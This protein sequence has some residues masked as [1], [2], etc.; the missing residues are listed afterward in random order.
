LLCT[1]IA[2]SAAGVQQ[3]LDPQLQLLAMGMAQAVGMIRMQGLLL[4]LLK[5]PTVHGMRWGVQ[6]ACTSS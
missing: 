1:A 2:A 4:L 3:A 5:L 6:R